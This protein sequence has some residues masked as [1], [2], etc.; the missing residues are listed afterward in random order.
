VTDP[1]VI[2][3]DGPTVIVGAG[4]SAATVLTLGDLKAAAFQ[5]RTWKRDTGYRISL[6]RVGGVLSPVML[7][8]IIDGQSLSTATLAELRFRLS[9]PRPDNAFMLE[10]EGG[11]DLQGP[12]KFGHKFT[13]KLRPLIEGST[14]RPNPSV[15][16]PVTGATT[17]YGS[18]NG[19]SI[20]SGMVDAI[21]DQ[22]EA[23]GLPID[24]LK[25]VVSIVGIGGKSYRELTAGT[26]SEAWA[27]EAVATAYGIARGKG[28]GFLTAKIREHGQTD[29]NQNPVAGDPEPVLSSDMT[30]LEYA[31]Y[32]VQDRARFRDM[33]REITGT[34]YDPYYFLIQCG[35]TYPGGWRKMDMRLANT[36]E[37]QRLASHMD[38]RIVLVGPDYP[39]VLID[40]LHMFAAGYN[41]LG[42]SIA[43]PIVRTLFGNGRYRAPEPI[44]ARRTSPTKIR[45]VVD[46]SGGE[47]RIQ[48]YQ[49]SEWTLATPGSGYVAGDEVRAIGMDTA[50][51]WKAK[52][53]PDHPGQL[54]WEMTDPGSHSTALNGI[55]ATQAQITGATVAS[56]GTGIAIDGAY[57]TVQGGTFTRAA[58]FT[59]SAPNGIPVA[60]NLF[61]A[62]DYSVLP[63]NPV[64][65]STSGVTGLTANINSLGSGATFHV[66]SYSQLAHTN[67]VPFFQDGASSS[68][69]DTIVTRGSGYGRGVVAYAVG[70]VLADVPGAHRASI[71]VGLIDGA[72]GVTNAGMRSGG[73]YKA[74]PP[75][76]VE[77]RTDDG[78]GTGCTIATPVSCLPVADPGNCG[79]D[80][81]DDTP[82]LVGFETQSGLRPPRVIDVQIVNDAD[83][84]QTAIDITVDQPLGRSTIVM[85]GQR[86]QGAN[87]PTA[88]GRCLIAGPPPK[89]SKPGP[90]GQYPQPW[91]IRGGIRVDTTDHQ[92]NR[93]LLDNTRFMLA[94]DGAPSGFVIPANSGVYPLDR[95]RAYRSVAGGLVSRVA[96]GR[97]TYAM[98]LQCAEGDTSAAQIQLSQV[99]VG[100]YV[101]ETI[102]KTLVLNVRGRFGAGAKGAALLRVYAFPTIAAFNGQLP[103]NPPDPIIVRNIPADQSDWGSRYIG[104][105]AQLAASDK[106]VPSDTQ[107]LIFSVTYTP[108]A[109]ASL[110]DDYFEFEEP[111]LNTGTLLRAF[112]PLTW[113]E[114]EDRAYRWY[115]KVSAYV[116]TAPTAMMLSP[117]M[118]AAPVVTGGGTGFASTNTT[119]DALVVSQST[120]AVQALTL[121]A[122]L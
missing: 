27:R 80:I 50:A 25:V 40:R 28:W 108:G 102:G 67:D 49:V 22:I 88:G 11:D 24:S 7:L 34:D 116:G 37:G 4:D 65:V 54:I 119:A 99:I 122:R 55:V 97:Q 35:S 9:Q 95:W 46:N 48:R 75:Q 84:T 117:P 3:Q 23:A 115:R 83:V 52:A 33:V 74:P 110:A 103:P 71:N 92:P 76:P 61:N 39:F 105:A 107:M 59:V 1:L 98:R 68:A 26:Q 18:G 63:S 31:S 60:L 42:R 12:I 109:A 118:R 66:L 56:L 82:V 70:G 8:L 45:V 85:F 10:L 17:A 93:P 29:S 106:V 100:E 111:S 114:E 101:S 32:C 47:L 14:T 120:P 121:N 77:Y 86:P 53:D 20:A 112:N 38:P 5:P 41:N 79:I 30:G 94:Q 15:T 21:F 44:L 81:D 73:V 57:A 64:A 90:L 72:G 113:A 13:G 16:D 2:T 69:P 87:G 62:G 58:V 89:G 78:A 96:G 6:P 51:R 43:E 19:E 91:I 36:A 104:S